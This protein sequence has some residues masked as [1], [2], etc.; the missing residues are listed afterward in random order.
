L[1]PVAVSDLHAFSVVLHGVGE[2][3]KTF[4]LDLIDIAGLHEDGWLTRR[5]DAARRAGDDHIASFQ[6]HRD[7]DR[8][9]QHR[10]TEDEQVSARILHL[11]LIHISSSSDIALHDGTEVA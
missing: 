7:T 4:D 10:D 5:A 8:C 1:M 6:T 3:T 9:N 11:S 2:D